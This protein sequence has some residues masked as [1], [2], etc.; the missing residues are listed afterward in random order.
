MLHIAEIVQGA[1][2]VGD[3]IE[4]QQH[5]TFVALER[6]VLQIGFVSEVWINRVEVLSPVPRMFRCTLLDKGLLLCF[7]G[8]VDATHDIQ[9]H[10]NHPTILL[11]S[12]A[13]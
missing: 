1:H 11:A 13:G 7:C 2:V 9:F 6:K 4:H 3:D 5:P 10:C 8:G 12:P